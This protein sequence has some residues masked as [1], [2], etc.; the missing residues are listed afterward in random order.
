MYE[1]YFIFREKMMRLEKE[2]E[3][4]LRRL[5]ADEDTPHTVI[6]QDDDGTTGILLAEK[7]LVINK[8]K[9]ISVVVD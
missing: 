6:A 1:I 4:L 2:N 5:E 9:D 7:T 8:T 3:I